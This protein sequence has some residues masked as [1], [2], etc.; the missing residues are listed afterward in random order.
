MQHSMQE[1]FRRM[2][3]DP[4]VR[5]PVGIQFDGGNAREITM[6]DGRGWR[7]GSGWSEPE[8]PYPQSGILRRL[9]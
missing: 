2:I 9:W 7:P 1:A 8:G 5:I 6:L 4:A 3:R